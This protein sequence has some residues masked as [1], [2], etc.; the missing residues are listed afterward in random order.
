MTDFLTLWRREAIGK[1]R[2]MAVRATNTG[3]ACGS[4]QRGEP[5]AYAAALLQIGKEYEAASRCFQE[6][7]PSADLLD[8]IANAAALCRSYQAHYFA[9]RSMGNLRASKAA[10]STLD[11][12]LAERALLAQGQRQTSIFDQKDA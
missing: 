2:E 11:R 6:G 10:E 4:T 12:L 5:T 7:T 3:E 8:R 1:L 9:D